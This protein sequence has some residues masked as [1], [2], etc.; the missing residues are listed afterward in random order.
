AILLGKV[1][2]AKGW[3]FREV[4]K[5]V[6][7]TTSGYRRALHGIL[8]YKAVAVVLFFAGLGAT[9]FVYRSVPT[10]FVPVEDQGYFFI[11]VQGPPGASL[12]YTTGILG[13]VQKYLSIVPE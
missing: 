13:Q 7:A 9:Y 2:G 12:E 8:N 4:D 10:A 11:L 1:H 3:V 5:I 6:A